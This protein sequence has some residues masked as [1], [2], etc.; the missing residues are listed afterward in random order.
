MKTITM[1]GSMKFEREMQAIA[2]CLETKY[3]FN[4]LQC[5]YNPDKQELTPHDL[6]ALKKAHFRKIDMSDGIYVVDIDGYIGSSVREEINY[7]KE[8]GKQVILHTGFAEKPLDRPD[9]DGNGCF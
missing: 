4:V 7:A 3:G 5:V 1:C 2:L 6:E 9:R 8:K